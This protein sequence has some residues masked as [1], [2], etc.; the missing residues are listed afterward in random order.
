[1]R[2]TLPGESKGFKTS[3]LDVQNGDTAGLKSVTFLIDGPF[4]YGLMKSE[5]GVHR[6]VR[7]SPYDSA[8][9][10]HT[11]FASVYV[12]PDIDDDIEIEI[13]L[14]LKL[15]LSLYLHSKMVKLTF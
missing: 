7:I 8:N 2:F 12:S 1:M 5:S 13:V 15:K 14:N 3:V 6:L 10:R 11:T 9:R 4:A